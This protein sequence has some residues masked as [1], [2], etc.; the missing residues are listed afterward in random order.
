M[1]NKKHITIPMKTDLNGV[2]EKNE[3]KLLKSEDILKKVSEKIEKI[4]FFQKADIKNSD[5]K[6]M[7]HHYLVIVVEEL[8]KIVEKN[9][10]GLAVKN[11]FI[12]LFNIE[13]WSIINSKE[14]QY[15]LVDVAIKMG[16]DNVMSKYYSFGDDLVKQ[17][18]ALARP[19]EIL[20]FKGV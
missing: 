4:D 1:K 12:Y 16:V 9:Q 10:W 6:L 14:F 18:Y 11:G 13:Y 15:F 8:L 17:F 3:E 7:R 20:D 5:K 19:P 2:T